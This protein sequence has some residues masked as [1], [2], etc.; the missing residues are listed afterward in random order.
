[1]ERSGSQSLLNPAGPPTHMQAAA[2]VTTMRA[3]L[4]NER[5]QQLAV[6]ITRLEQEQAESTAAAKGEVRT[7]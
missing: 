6:V 4:V 3:E 2:R 1:M 7:I 5:D